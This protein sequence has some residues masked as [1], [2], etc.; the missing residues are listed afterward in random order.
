MDGWK[1]KLLKQLFSDTDH[2]K[3][4]TWPIE[5]H[6]MTQP[7]RETKQGFVFSYAPISLQQKLESS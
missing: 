7:Q 5:K 6:C 3:S 4:S 1:A 2:A